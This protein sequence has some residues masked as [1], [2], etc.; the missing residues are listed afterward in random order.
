MAGFFR[1][2]SVKGQHLVKWTLP[3]DQADAD[4]ISSG[5][6]QY[7]LVHGKSTDDG[8][9]AVIA[10]PGSITHG[11]QKKIQRSCR[12]A[13]IVNVPITYQAVI[14]PTE[15]PG[16]FPDAFGND[17]SLFDHNDLLGYG[18]NW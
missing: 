5:A 2:G 1:F 4:Q 13:A 9:V 6:I 15:V 3:G 18:L 11:D 14:D 8:W 7:G 17:G 12:M 10:H 16:C